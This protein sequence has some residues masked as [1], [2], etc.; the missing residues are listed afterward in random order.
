VLS[1][2]NP[3]SEV[4]LE[5]IT[6]HRLQPH[7]QTSKQCS[8]PVLQVMGGVCPQGCLLSQLGP[9]LLPW[10]DCDFGSRDGKSGHQLSP[11]SCPAQH[12]TK[13]FHSQ[14]PTQSL[15]LPTLSSG[16]SADWVAVDTITGW[17]ALSQSKQRLR[18]QL[19]CWS[20]VVV[21]EGA[22]NSISKTNRIF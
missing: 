2:A 4:L 7:K 5:R 3:A 19:G 21:G 22:G 18:W 17:H 11:L 10:G 15:F 9:T 1:P 14:G 6:A 20:H 16:V 8:M 13:W 12:T